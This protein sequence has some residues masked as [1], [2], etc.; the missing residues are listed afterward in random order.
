MPRAAAIGIVSMVFLA[1]SIVDA[2][3]FAAAKPAATAARA[4]PLDRYLDGLKTLRVEF[5]QQLVDARG[6]EVQ[7]AVGRMVIVRPGRFRWEIGPAQEGAAAAP[8]EEAARQVLVADGRNLWFYDRDLEQVTV[9]PA[10]SVLTATPAMLLSG[11]GD[12][13]ESFDISSGGRSAG[14]EW[15]VV[16]PK[17]PEAEFRFARLGFARGQLARMV[18]EDKLGQTA[19]LDFARATRNGRVTPDEVAFVP[20]AGVDVIGKP[21]S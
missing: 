18:L 14:L 1:T 17:R 12:L 2:T 5:T 21:T 3:A 9:K 20:P 8:P 6:R 15:V 16:K 11:T 4:T 7:S 10:A 19:T 13:R